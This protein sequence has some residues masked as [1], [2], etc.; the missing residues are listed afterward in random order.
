MIRRYKY[1]IYP[2]PEQCERLYRWFAACRYVYNIAL[3][4]KKYAYQSQGVTIS[5]F[6]LS[7]DLKHIRKMSEFLKDVPFDALSYEL[8]NLDQAYKNF[9]KSKKGFPKFKSKYDKNT[10]TLKTCKINPPKI[11]IQKLGDVKIVY[12]RPM[13]GQPKGTTLIKTKAGDYYVSIVCEDGLPQPEKKPIEKSVGIDLGIEKFVI[14]S[15][16]K[17]YENLRLLDANLKRLR[18]LQRHFARQKK[19]SN[20]REQ[21][22]LKIAK[23][24]QRIAFQREA[25]LHRISS[26]IIQNNDLVSVED[27]AVKNMV[28]N[29]HLSKAISQ[30][31]WG[32]FVQQ[33]SYKAD[34]HGKT[35]QKINRFFPSSKTCNFCGYQLESL[36]LSVRSWECPGCGEV[37]D[38]DIN[39]AK[40]IDKEGRVRALADA[41]VKQ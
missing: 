26:A 16:G 34:I 35:L 40:N 23:L 24:H 17:K 29:K 12:H 38:R 11:S 18:A 37:H 8:A 32:M 13:P 36:S 20:R 14:T 33:L 1:R 21:T 39:A 10:I 22:R 7:S 31:G 28:K 5:R 19:G 15:D 27:L 41:K 3:E 2:T 25:Y 6:T 9:F 30:I 4:T